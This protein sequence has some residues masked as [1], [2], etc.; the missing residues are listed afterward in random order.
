MPRDVNQQR[1]FLNQMVNTLDEAEKNFIRSKTAIQQIFT[2]LT[3]LT[4]DSE[5]P[6]ENR[7]AIIIKMGEGKQLLK[8]MINN[9]VIPT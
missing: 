3:T 9:I 2:G 8:T 1:R 4:E 5:L 7:D 6:E